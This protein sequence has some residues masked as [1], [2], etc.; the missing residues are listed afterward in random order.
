MN[1]RF[2]VNFLGLATVSGA[3]IGMAKIVTTLYALEIGATPLQIGI[4]SAMEALGMVFLTLPAGFVIARYGTRRVY[5]L[6]SLGPLLLNL[7][8]PLFAHWLW[9][10]AARLLI[11][12][13]IPFRIV[14]MNSAFLQQLRHIGL[15][16]AGWYRCALTAGMGILGPLLGNWLSG[17]AGYGVAFGLIAASF[18]FMAL[19]SLGFWSAESAPLAEPASGAPEAGFLA[20]VK[21]MLGSPEIAESCLLEMLGSSSGA[22]YGTF[23]LLLAMDVAGLGRD[24]AVSLVMI[25]GV[26]A[27]LALFGLGTLVQRCG[28]DRAYLLALVAGLAALA[29]LGQARHY[30]LLALGGVLLSLAAA[31]LHL[32]NMGRLSE[33][34]VDKSK[35]SGLYNL[36]S[37]LGGFGGAMLG[38]LLS[39]WVGLE[40]LFLCWIPLVLVVALACRLLAVQRSRRTPSLASEN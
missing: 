10:A 31:L 11:G 8:I 25:Q 29:L 35:V 34:P 4:I 14:A 26:S 16:K 32:V 9:L 22:L 38:G 17:G 21:A 18:G 40:H 24:Q 2:L 30:G 12:L 28:R 6:A 39:Q 3:T 5:F 15:G 7:A 23:V 19:Y 36:A 33:L 13:C 20:Q 37:M 1:N 27:V